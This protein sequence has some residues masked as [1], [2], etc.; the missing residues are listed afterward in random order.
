M[1]WFTFPIRIDERVFILIWLFSLILV[2][3][4]CLMILIWLLLWFWLIKFRS[5]DDSC[6]VCVMFVCLISVCWFDGFINVFIWAWFGFWDF[7]N[8]VWF[9][10]S[11]LF[12][13]VVLYWVHCFHCLTLDL[14][15]SLCILQKLQG[16]FDL[17]SNTQSYLHSLKKAF[18]TPCGIV[19]SVCRLIIYS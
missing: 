1:L 5:C 8:W 2:G 6:S 7:F 18:V 10:F 12:P 19:D 9:W 17:N 13:S 11:R 15:F 4:E 3:S 14:Y 16:V